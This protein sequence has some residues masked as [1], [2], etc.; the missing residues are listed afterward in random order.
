MTAALKKRKTPAEGEKSAI[1]LRHQDLGPLHDLLL[2]ACPPDPV[3]GIKSIAGLAIRLGI[4]TWA[5]HKWVQKG[6]IPPKRAA[7]VVDISDGRVSLH[8]FSPFVYV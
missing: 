3:T 1:I 7:E 2:K 8:E 6:K 4:S 5:V